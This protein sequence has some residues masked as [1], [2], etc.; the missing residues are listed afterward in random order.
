MVTRKG[1]LFHRDENCPG[2]QQGVRIS[3]KRA[4]KLSP[5]ELV[6]AQQAKERGK[7]C[8]SVCW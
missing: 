2:Y 1:R 8:C 7:G 4:R 5:V 3:I 6:T